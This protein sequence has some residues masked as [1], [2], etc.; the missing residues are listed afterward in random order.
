MLE[1]ILIIADSKEE[2]I[3]E[4]K[5]SGQPWAPQQQA[6]VDFLLKE[7]PL[8]WRSNTD[9][10]NPGAEGQHTVQL[11]QFLQK[12]SFSSDTNCKFGAG[13]VPKTTLGFI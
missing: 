13:G 12:A 6:F 7:S 3:Q 11:E 10:Q 2:L 1:K 5:E 4:E 8:L 9:S